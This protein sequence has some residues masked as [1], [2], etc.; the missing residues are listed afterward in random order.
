MKNTIRQILVGC[1][2]LLSTS[3]YYD[4]AIEEEIELPPPDE[5]ISFEESVLPILAS[6]N[7]AQCHNGNTAPD[8]R[9]DNAYDALVPDFVVAG[10]AE[11]SVF[12][13]RLPGKDHPGVGISLRSSEIALIAEWI[14]RGAE[15]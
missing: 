14:N 10:D 6:Y 13:Q 4:T 9:P 1:L 5:G 7:C 11:A 3:C 8:L 2:L 12:F 15:E